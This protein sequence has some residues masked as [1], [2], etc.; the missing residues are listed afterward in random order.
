MTE[1]EKAT[2]TAA[3]QQTADLAVEVVKL[4][5]RA[6]TEP[7]GFKAALVA[8]APALIQEGREAIG[9]VKDALPVIKAGKS[10]SEFWI[11]AGVG[12]VILAARLTGHPLPVNEEA[13]AA[14]LAA[15]Y[16]GGRSFVK[17]KAA[18]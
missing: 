16:T 7:G 1:Q 14:G 4:I 9:A 10:T 8:E 15:V 5:R 2:L 18:E 3:E 17:G 6:K 12:G 11:T 13:L